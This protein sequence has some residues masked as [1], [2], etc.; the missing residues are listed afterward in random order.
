M[1]LI[2][3]I[4]IAAIA[5]LFALLWPTAKNMITSNHTVFLKIVGG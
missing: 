1:T 4:A 3:S 2:T 5:G